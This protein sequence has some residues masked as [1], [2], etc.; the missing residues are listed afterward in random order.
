MACGEEMV[1]SA[2]DDARGRR[3]QL[4]KEA[5]AAAAGLDDRQ[6]RKGS[7]GHVPWRAAGRSTPR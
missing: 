2:L 5:A 3:M 6:G 7:G 1:V 4:K